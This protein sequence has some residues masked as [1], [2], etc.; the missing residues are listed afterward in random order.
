[1][2]SE[3]LQRYQ[4]K[5]LMMQ[6]R[7]RDEIQRMIQVVLDNDVTAGEHDHGVSESFD[8][9]LVLEHTEQAMQ[10]MVR[11]ALTRIEEGTYGKCLQCCRVIPQVRLNAIPFTPYCVSCEREYEK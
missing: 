11:S 6:D 7:T 5:L 2:K 3:C 8:K 4:Q 1:M 9:E 10:N